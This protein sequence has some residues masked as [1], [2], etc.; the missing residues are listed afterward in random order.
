M[1]AASSNN[2]PGYANPAF[3]HLLDAAAANA[4]S[5]RRRELLE[6]SERLMLTGYPVLL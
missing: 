4:D 5:G 3:D 6:S 2:D 1:R